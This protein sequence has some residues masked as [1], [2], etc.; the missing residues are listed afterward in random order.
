MSLDWLR[1]TN[2]VIPYFL[3]LTLYLESSPLLLQKVPVDQASTTDSAAM[4]ERD[5]VAIAAAH[6]TCHVGQLARGEYGRISKPVKRSSRMPLAWGT[7]WRR[8]WLLSTFGKT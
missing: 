8:P 7:S 6:P 1:M 4:R 3:W 5:G 2:A